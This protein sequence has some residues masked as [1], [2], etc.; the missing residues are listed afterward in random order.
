MSSWSPVWIL[1]RYASRCESKPLARLE[2]EMEAMT[3]AAVAAL[4]VYDMV[5]KNDRGAVLRHVQLLHKS[6]GASGTFDR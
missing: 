1:K 6:G 5:K 3:A 2:S 4:N